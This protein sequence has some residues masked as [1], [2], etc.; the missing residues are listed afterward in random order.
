VSLAHRE[1]GEARLD[2]ATGRPLSWRLEQRYRHATRGEVRDV[3]S[4]YEGAV[5]PGGG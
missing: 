4:V 2:V 1:R 5:A 3:T